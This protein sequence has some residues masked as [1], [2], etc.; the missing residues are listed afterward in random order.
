MRV[1][2]RIASGS[3]AG[4]RETFEKSVITVGRHPMNDFRFDVEKDAD[5][6]DSTNGTFV[7][8]Q[9]VVG[10]RALFDGDLIAFGDVGP[11]V[12]FHLIA[13]AAAPAAMR[14]GNAT[15]AGGAPSLPKA[16]APAAPATPAR[17]R[18]DTTARIAEAVEAQTGKL[19]TMIGALAGLVVVGVGIAY[20]TGNRGST[21]AQK[22]VAALLRQND[23][24][25]KA[26]D[27]AIGQ[28]QGRSAGVDSAL[29]AARRESELL[30]SRLEAAATGGDAAAVAAITSDIAAKSARHRGL[31]G[32][33]Q[34]DWEGVNAKNAAAMVFIVADNGDDGN[35]IGTGFNVS[36]SGLIVTN[37]H[38][39]RDSKGK[40]SRRVAVKF[41]GAD[42]K[43]QLVNVVK[44]SETDELA[45]LKIEGGGPYPTVAG[46]AR[47]P[48]A[49]VGA[50]VALIGYPLGTSTAGMGGDINTLKP[51]STLTVGTVSKVLG[52]TLQLDVYAAQGSSGSPV[53]N[54]QGIVVGVLFGAPAESNGRIIYAVPSSKVAAQ[55]PGEGAGVVK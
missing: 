36:P 55:M 24:L 19:R 50:P 44:V 1:E 21:E 32:A 31:L 20:W 26:F 28:L 16:E 25:A 51:V 34:V 10:E 11:K 4:Q 15:P 35:E 30:R 46:V 52:D 9:R 5:D 53:F 27:A 38:V 54:T 13:E 29:R 37:R 33:A 7:N 48:D 40:P 6:L 47:A 18:R 8:G 41:N 14:R 17:P 42:G 2:F 49:R 23:S 22:Q 43:F 45:W 3:R 12:E 39:V